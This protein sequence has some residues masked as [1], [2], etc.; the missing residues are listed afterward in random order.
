MFRMGGSTENVGIMDGMRNRY[1][2]GGPVD[3]ILSDLDKRAP[4]ADPGIYDFLQNFGL[5]ILSNPSQGNIFQTAAVAARDPAM[6]LQQGRAARAAERRQIAASVLAG[7]REFEQKKELLEME[8]AGRGDTEYAKEAMENFPNDSRSVAIA[9]QRI[10]DNTPGVNTSAQFLPSDAKS[11]VATLKTGAFNPGTIF[12]I[13]NDAGQ[14]VNS[15]AVTTSGFVR[16]DGFDGNTPLLTPVELKNG[17]FVPISKAIAPDEDTPN[18]E[19]MPSFGL[20]IDDPQA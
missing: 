12:T 19:P 18:M 6:M 2:N 9:K 8:L 5:N 11:R 3:Q 17:Q 20:D 16:F 7:E 14:L 13:V 4:R 15:P 10:I 1:D